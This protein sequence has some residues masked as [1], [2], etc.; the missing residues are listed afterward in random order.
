[1]KVAL[2]LLEVQD[3]AKAL[4]SRMR[5]W[6]QLLGAPVVVVEDEEGVVSLLI[7]TSGIGDRNPPAALVHRPHPELHGDGAA[8]PVLEIVQDQRLHMQRR[9]VWQTRHCG[10]SPR[11]ARLF[12]APL[13]LPG[14]RLQRDSVRHLAASAK[15]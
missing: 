4:P 15:V 2:L 12:A 7:A 11:A 10:S 5:A 8:G 1:M 3:A 13:A 9:S 6:R 14:W